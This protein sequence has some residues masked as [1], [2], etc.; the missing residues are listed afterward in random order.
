MVDVMRS[1]HPAH[2]RGVADDDDL[3]GVRV[4][5]PD[6]GGPLTWTCLVAG[7]GFEPGTFGL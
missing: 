7:A 6:R 3:E 1:G 5:P 4:R 2:T